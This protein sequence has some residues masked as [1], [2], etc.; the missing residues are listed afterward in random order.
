MRA[1]RI[2]AEPAHRPAPTGRGRSIGFILFMLALTI[3]FAALGAWQ[4]LRLGEKEALIAAVAAR[5]ELPPVPL[6]PTAEWPHLDSQTLDFRPVTL[7][8]VFEP[9]GTVLVFT[10][11]SAAK[12]KFSGPGYWVMVPVALANGGLVFVN[13]GFVPEQVAANMREGGLVGAD[14][15]ELTGLARRSEALNG[16]TPGADLG[17]R[18]DY[19]RNIARL[20]AQHP[21][22]GGRPF[23]PVYVDLPA[24]EPGALPQ[25]GETVMQF[26][27]RHLDYALTWFGLALITP[28]L[29]LVWLLRQRRRA[30]PS[31]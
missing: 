3:L 12:G 13:R 30:P 21:A 14:P 19:V 17:R 28:V 26:P 7:S 11:L 1:G 5:A 9:Q 25:G 18:I 24:G 23:A 22:P 6:P 29:S 4:V 15:V 10:S 8:G 16:F 27:N 2:S 31:A 20:A